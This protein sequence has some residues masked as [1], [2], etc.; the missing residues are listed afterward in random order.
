MNR[1]SPKKVHRRLISK[2]RDFLHPMSLENCIF[3]K[4]ATTTHQVEGPKSKTLPIPNVDKDVEQLEQRVMAGGS[5]KMVQPLWKI[6]CQIL[7]K[8]NILLLPDPEISIDIYENGLKKCCLQN[9]LHMEIYSNFIQSCQKLEAVK[10]S[11]SRWMNEYH[12]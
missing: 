11:L 1:Y 12:I 6:I 4:W 2:W 7:I 3:R 9:K 5:A 8:L 10:I